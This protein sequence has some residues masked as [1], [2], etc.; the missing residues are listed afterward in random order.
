MHGKR[1]CARGC[2]RLEQ[3]S[4][5]AEADLSYEENAKQVGANE[6][7]TYRFAVL[8]TVAVLLIPIWLVQYPGMIDL[9]NHLARC[10]IFAHYSENAAWQQQFYI[11][12]TPLPNLAIDAIVVPLQQFFPLLICSRIFLSLTALVYLLGCVISGA[13][14]A[15]RRS[16]MALPAALTFFSSPL[17][18]GFVNYVFGVGVFLCAFGYWLQI[19]NA[20]TVWRF[21]ICMLLSLVCY[22][23]HLSSAAV[24]GV[25]CLVV[26]I[27]DWMGERSLSRFC[28]KTF[29]LGTP[30]VLV[31]V[32]MHGSG[33]VGS[34]VYGSLREKLIALLGPVRSYDSALDAAVLCGLIA[35][36]F[37]LIRASRI[38]CVA[39]AGAFCFLL[40]W[41][42]PKM[43]FTSSAADARWM[44]PCYLLLILSLTPRW[45]GRT[46]A[47]YAVVI[48]LLAIHIA[49]VAVHWVRINNLEQHVVAMGDAVPDAAKVFSINP[50]QLSLTADERGFYNSMVLWEISRHAAVNH[51]FTLAG[52]QPLVFRQVPCENIA[53]VHCLSTYDYIW[54]QKPQPEIDVFL[55]RVASPVSTWDGVTVWRVNRVGK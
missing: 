44:M 48:A 13:A 27:G 7:T 29:W 55:R 17:L 5:G 54:A 39:W 43:M 24:L 14:I 3:K 47:A 36:F 25:A 16:W 9:P 33:Q 15:K 19:R 45:T 10:Y 4:V 23:S 22:C 30:C 18:W 49:D 53:D 42:T 40:F 35:A 52:Q 31:L 11:D 46:K 20:M 8:A 26:A 41:I 34:I 51:I 50:S 38:S 21:V 32:F 37:I 1:V 12:H 6:R 2:V 28:T